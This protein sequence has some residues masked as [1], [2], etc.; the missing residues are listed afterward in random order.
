[1]P[2]ESGRSWKCADF[3][4]V[5]RVYATRDEATV[6]TKFKV[7]VPFRVHYMGEGD[8]TMVDRVILGED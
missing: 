4:R 7:G 8:S 1:M 3:A 6:R 2:D 5:D